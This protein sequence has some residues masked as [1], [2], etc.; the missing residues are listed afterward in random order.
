MKNPVAYFD[1][2]LGDESPGEIMRKLAEVPP[3]YI[4]SNIAKQN[5]V[6]RVFFVPASWGSE[7]AGQWDG[8][9]IHI[10]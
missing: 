6:L 5:Y 2:E 7:E 9:N 4:I 10:T 8:R 3:D 1:V